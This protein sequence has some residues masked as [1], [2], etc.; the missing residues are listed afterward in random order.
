MGQQVNVGR[1]LIFAPGAIVKGSWNG[2]FDTGG[3]TYYVN[4]ITGNSTADGLSWNSAMSQPSYA[5]TASATLQALRASGNE[6]VRNTIVMQ[7]TSTKYT[8]I[9]TMPLYTNMIG[10][11]SNPRGNAFGNV[12][13]GDTTDEADGAAGDEAGNYWYN[14]QFSGG[15]S[16][17]AVDLGVSFSST[18]DNCTFGT[19]SDNAASAGGIRILTSMSGSSFIDCDNIAHNGWPAYGM[20]ICAAGSTLVANQVRIDHCFWLG[21]TAGFYTKAYLAGGSIV[22]NSTLRGGTN[23]GHDESTNSTIVAGFFYVGN[24]C[25]GTT[26][27]LNITNN[28]APRAIGNWVVNNVTGATLTDAT[29]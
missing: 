15:G 6:P 19:A 25:T 4:N 2:S 13:M 16:F 5:I 9:S 29:G 14:I 24:Y 7:G 17:W 1:E 10:L 18:W 27:G 8:P 23:G 22:Q 28:S 21:S 3:T 12:R 26:T 11:G 20:Q